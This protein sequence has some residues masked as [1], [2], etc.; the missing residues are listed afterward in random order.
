MGISEEIEDAKIA[1]EKKRRSQDCSQYLK[2]D[3]N[4]RDTGN[5]E[6]SNIELQ[7]L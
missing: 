4:S 6:Q 2:I 5:I 7:K 1:S 3:L